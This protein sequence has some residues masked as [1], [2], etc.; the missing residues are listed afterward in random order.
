MKTIS[1]GGRFGEDAANGDLVLRG[2]GYAVVEAAD[3][4]DG[5]SRTGPTGWA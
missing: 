2:A 4:V 1:D 5:L 3:G